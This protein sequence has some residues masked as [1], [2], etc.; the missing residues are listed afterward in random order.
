M[1][2]KFGN[3]KSQ[4]SLQLYSLKIIFHRITRR[5]FP[6]SPAWCGTEIECVLVGTAGAA[7]AIRA[8]LMLACSEC[9]LTYADAKHN[10]YINMVFEEINVLYALSHRTYCIQ[11]NMLC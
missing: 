11:S 6:I 4:H 2:R 5:I 9:I 7:A 8:E 3:C 1:V 10:K